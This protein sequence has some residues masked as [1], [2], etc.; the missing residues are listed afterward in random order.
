MSTKVYN[1]SETLLELINVG[2]INKFQICHRI[3]EETML[4]F[5]DKL[6]WEEVL[7]HQKISETFVRNHLINIVRD[8]N[9]WSY[10]LRYQ[11]LSEDFLIEN[12]KYFQN[13]NLIDIIINQKVTDKFLNLAFA[14]FYN[15]SFFLL[16]IKYQTLSNDFIIEHINNL[17]YFDVIKYQENLSNEVIEKILSIDKSKKKQKKLC[18]LILKYYN[19]PIDM[20]KKYFYKYNCEQ[21]VAYQYNLPYEYIENHLQEIINC[22]KLDLIARLIC[23]NKLSIDIINKLK[24]K[25]TNYHW[26]LICVKQDLPLSFFKDNWDKAEQYKKILKKRNIL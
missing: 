15:L 4:Y 1:V 22:D 14:H 3:S 25:L 9:L 7:M 16:I 26:K 12:F 21:I 8:Q 24:D 11:K 13:N 2:D 5:F 23:K 17:D 18:N 19:L 20:L 6:N 10:L